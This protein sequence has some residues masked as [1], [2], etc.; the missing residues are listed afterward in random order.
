MSF[1]Q[2]LRTSAPAA[3][4]RKYDSSTTQI[5]DDIKVIIAG[6]INAGKS[7]LI[8]ALLGEILL[9]AKITGHTAAVHYC[10]YG[11]LR[12]C[13]VYFKDQARP[14]LALPL[15]RVELEQFLNEG[16]KDVQYVEVTH[17]AIPE[18]V[19]LIDT[20]GIND[21]D[22]Y[23][24]SLVAAFMSQADALIFVFDVNQ[25]LKR[26]ELAFLGEHVRKFRLKQCLFLANKADVER[27]GSGDIEAERRRFYEQLK[28]YVSA[29][30]Q[31]DQAVLVSARPRQE[32]PSDES[33]SPMQ[34]VA[35]LNL[36][37][38]ERVR[39]IASRQ[40]RRRLI[41]TADQENL[42]R[43]KAAKAEKSQ[44]TIASVLRGYQE[45][46]RRLLKAHEELEQGRE[47]FFAEV[48]TF[49]Q[50]ELKR[51]SR[52]LLPIL[53]M[54]PDQLQARANAIVSE[55]MDRVGRMAATKLAR[56]PGIIALTFPDLSD[57]QTT[58]EAAAGGQA[59]EAQKGMATHGLVGALGGLVCMFAPIAG[60]AMMA[61]SAFGHYRHQQGMADT[62]QRAQQAGVALI[63]ERLSD[64]RDQVLKF[65]RSWYEEQIEASTAAIKALLLDLYAA[66]MPG[67]EGDLNAAKAE[68][69]RIETERRVILSD[70][71]KEA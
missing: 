31:Y 36:L 6:E 24:D 45:R 4:A 46:A 42:L 55:T 67:Q 9:P 54:P 51:T 13:R 28:T 56:N 15:E 11:T 29:D 32:R 8:N 63:E 50:E 62:I 18:G 33:I 21:P 20:P 48:E 40:L 34:V 39:I 59:S 70:L 14:P 35:R 16:G 7:S 10:K 66:S 37:L 53:G 17:P 58:L 27:P 61:L 57:V 68:L 49:L 12:S 23:R 25:A 60:L 22:P 3:S 64:I 41:E 44:E 26:S 2:H 71:E 65:F 38:K 19:V 47:S 30:I 52:M 69:A 5:V 43:L 1:L